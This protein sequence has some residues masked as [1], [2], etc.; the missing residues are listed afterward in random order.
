MSYILTFTVKPESRFYADYF[1]AKAEK[2]HFRDLA[3][4]FLE[5]HGIE[6]DAYMAE[7]L[8]INPTDRD[9]ERWGTHILKNHDSRGYHRFRKYS[10]IEKEW[11]SDVAAKVN[12]QVLEKRDLWFF[13]FIEAGMYKLWD[14]NGTIYGYL[15]NRCYRDIT[16][17]ESW[18][19]PIKVSEY[20]A[21]VEAYEDEVKRKEM[22]G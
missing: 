4:P 15:E 21:A 16:P 17:N 9:V 14:W 3:I 7:F 13:D 20:Y 12:F 6:G 19:Q 22:E 5:K 18:M 10:P 8:A 11:E 2:K 1:A